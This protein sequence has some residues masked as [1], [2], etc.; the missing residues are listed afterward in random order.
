M[1]TGAAVLKQTS[2]KFAYFYHLLRPYEHYVPFWQN[3]SSDILDAVKV[4]HASSQL[5][6]ESS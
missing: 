6:Q 1:L 4:D 5:L 3:S 2:P